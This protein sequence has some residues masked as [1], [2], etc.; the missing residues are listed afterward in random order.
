MRPQ[1]PGCPE[2]SQ[3]IVRDGTFKRA[4]DS[5]HIQRFRC[6]TCGLGFSASTGTPRYRQKCRRINPR[7]KSLFCKGLS[8]RELAD[9]LNVSRKTIARRITW[10]ADE[11]RALQRRHMEQYVEQKG[12]FKQLQFDELHTFE[13]TKCKPTTIGIVAEQTTRFIL[14][15]C[16]AQ[17]PASGHLAAISRKKYGKRA[18]QSGTARNDLFEELAPFID[19][20]LCIKTDEHKRYPGEIKKHFPDATH[21]QY[22]SI[23]GCVTG[24]GEMK[25]TQFDPLFSI[26]HTLAMLRYKINR[27]ARR[28]W[29]TTKLNARLDDHVALY[30]DVHNRKLIDSGVM[31]YRGR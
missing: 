20:K 22:K 24:Q 21:V 14:G 12:L 29:C 31:H 18:D 27:L 26:N 3:H 15:H 10:L 25:K 30:I 19:E 13:H 23:K 9:E 1:C 17:I 2:S 4:C 6:K 5:R 8:Q 7:L 28:T 11:A 16:V